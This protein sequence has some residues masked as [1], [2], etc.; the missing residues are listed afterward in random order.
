MGGGVVQNFFLNAR[1]KQVR[2]TKLQIQESTACFE[3]IPSK[4]QNKNQMILTP[5]DFFFFLLGLSVYCTHKENLEGW[6][7]TAILF[8][9]EC[10][11]FIFNA[12][13]SINL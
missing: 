8:K 5:T 11:L 9:T 2:K 3:S 7:F 6:Q 13:L 10:I 4:K 1:S 12:V